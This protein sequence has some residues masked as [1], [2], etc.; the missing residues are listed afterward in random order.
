MRLDFGDSLQDYVRGIYCRSDC[1]LHSPHYVR[2][3][4]WV[5]IARGFDLE[6]DQSMI[7]QLI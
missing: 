2:G 6:L 1:I 4:H 7:I 3:A 5:K